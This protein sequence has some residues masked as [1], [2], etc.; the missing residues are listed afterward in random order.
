MPASVDVDGRFREVPI[1]ALGRNRSVVIG[2][3]QTTRSLGTTSW[4]SMARRCPEPDRTNP[5]CWRGS[6]DLQEETWG[7]LLVTKTASH[8]NH[9][10]RRYARLITPDV[11]GR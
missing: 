1:S 2:R 6:T 11:G 5:S 7:E 10:R 4:R 9:S 8:P 3:S